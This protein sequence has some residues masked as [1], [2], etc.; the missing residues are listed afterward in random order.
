MRAI[1]TTLLSAS[2]S[3][4]GGKL[5]IHTSRAWPN[6]RW[7]MF[8]RVICHYSSLSTTYIW[9]I[10]WS[11]MKW[12]MNDYDQDIL[13]FSYFSTSTVFK[14]ATKFFV[15]S[16]RNHDNQHHALLLWRSFHM[17][18]IYWVYLKRVTSWMRSCNNH[19]FLKFR[20][21]SP[22]RQT[23]ALGKDDIISTLSREVFYSCIVVSCPSTSMSGT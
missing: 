10:G 16:F 8:I 7:T 11:I 3:H 14:F 15:P 20:S 4:F 9:W 19:F 22:W 18:R 23:S 6:G 5:S 1:T 12:K 13:H 2:W 17:N 21:S